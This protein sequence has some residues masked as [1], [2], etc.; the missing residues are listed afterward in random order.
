M[1][2]RVRRGMKKVLVIFIV[3]V[4]LYAVFNLINNNFNWL[5]FGN[6]ENQATVTDQIEKIEIDVTN[7][8]TTI[9]PDNRNDIKAELEGKGKL[10]VDKNGDQIN[11]EV[12]RTGFNWISW[13][14]FLNKTKLTIYIPEDYDRNLAIELGAGN[15]NFSGQ[16]KNQPMKLDELTLDIGSGNMKLKNLEVTQFKHDGSSGNVE[17]DSLITKNGSFDISSGSLDIKHYQG[18]FKADLSSGKLNLQIDKLKDSVDIDISSGKV[19]VDLPDK[20][21]FTLNGKVSSGNISSAF[22]IV[23]KDFNTKNIKGTHG[24]GKHPINLTVS[25][26][27]I[28]IY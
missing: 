20:A 13:F 16:S 9:I 19:E 21:D 25:S 15:L 23:S 12:K 17:V 27:T 14:N 8:S 6:S 28:H 5:P 2:G 4:G 10:I 3:L 26:G 24:S 18:S 7:V 22:P 1:G 11:V